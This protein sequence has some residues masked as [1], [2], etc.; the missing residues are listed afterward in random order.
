M[1]D[2]NDNNLGKFVSIQKDMQKLWKVLLESCNAL[3]YIVF[4]G[5]IP[6]WS[7]IAVSDSHEFLLEKEKDNQLYHEPISEDLGSRFGDI[8]FCCTCPLRCIGKISRKL[9]VTL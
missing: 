6:P 1:K 5:L 9:L 3:S 7:H 2:D 8:T 4:D